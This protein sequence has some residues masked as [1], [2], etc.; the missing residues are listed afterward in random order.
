VYIYIGLFGLLNFCDFNDYLGISRVSGQVDNI[1]YVV[2][3]IYGGSEFVKSGIIYKFPY[4]EQL[5][6]KKN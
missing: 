5:I 4:L 1:F 2:I 6:A 3:G